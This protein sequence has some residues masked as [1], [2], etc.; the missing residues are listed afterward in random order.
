MRMYLD[1]ILG[2]T[3]KVNALSVLISNPEK[4]FMEVELA[5]E[6]GSPVSEVN[7]QMSDLVN[8]G[9]VLVQRVGRA[10]VYQINSKHF[11][12]S[13]IRKL[14]RSLE[15]VYREIA[16]KIVSRVAKHKPK[17]IILFGSLSKGKIRSNIVKEPSDIDLIVVADKGDVH[18]IRNEM[19]RFINEE[20]SIR[21][22]VVVYPIVL[23]LEE[24]LK[25]LSKDQF[26]ID[27]HSKGELLYGEKPHRFG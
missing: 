16:K 1:R 18:K 4:S 19:L 2:S 3:T 20:I 13:P 23:S 21:Y 7:R 17:A 26:I 15:S 12:Y 24:Y 8:S 14:F 25:G 10:K 27:A 9:L 11:L 6:S 22:G 5:R